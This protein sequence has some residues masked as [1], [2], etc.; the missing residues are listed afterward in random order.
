[1]SFRTR[2]GLVVAAS[3]AVAV[4]AISGVALWIARTEA[5]S[6]LDQQLDDRVAVLVT[7]G[8]RLPE[9]RGVQFFGRFVPRDVLAQIVAP[10]G[11]VMYASDGVLPVGPADL[12]VANGQARPHRADV[13]ADG[14]RLRVLT[15]PIT[16]VGALMV[17][18][19]LD[20]VDANV[21]GL[22]NAL[23]VVAVIGVAGAGLLG[24]L[25]AGRAIRPVR[26]LTDAARN[27][28]QTQDLEQP[29][30]LERDD[31]LGELARSFNAMLEALAQSRTQQHRLVT[32]AGHELRTPLTS[33]R[34]NIELL[35]RAEQSA[36][37]AEAATTSGAA[38]TN[39]AVALAGDERRQMLDDVQ[40]ELDQLTELV[41]ELVELATDQR[42]QAEPEPVDLAELAA[43][44]VDRHR[45]RTEADF[46]TDIEP[47]E[48][49]ANA[50]LVER[51]IGNLVDNAVKWSPPGEPIEIS[52]AAA[53]REAHVRVR[54]YGPG[55]PVALRET[56]FERF[57]RAPE[58]RSQPG[59][60]LG[61]SI[62]DYVARTHG[63]TASVIDT[64]GGGTTVELRLPLAEHD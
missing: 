37:P 13:S 15:V 31:E 56:V 27:V 40:F 38:G 53:D 30:E 54:D 32:D 7:S 45:R 26:R 35:A 11:A 23:A 43:S 36:A 20:E 58:A 62:V 59:S 24:F 34:T 18:R 57:Y 28:A 14:V 44:V 48:V 17:A 49:V 19:P 16:P 3:V 64:D 55:I 2:L 21:E 5:R 41:S 42:S 50:V 61:L 6:A 29:I 10:N 9:R 25:V 8:G 33:I 39:M 12:A 4:L 52:V 60:G 51:A 47:C 22:R 63:G 1:M 46:V